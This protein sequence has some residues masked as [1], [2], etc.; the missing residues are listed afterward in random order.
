MP[1][2]DLSQLSEDWQP[3]VGPE[4]EALRDGLLRS[5]A[6]G[7]ALDSAVVEPVAIR[8]HRK[9]LICWLPETDSLAWVHLTGKAETDPRWPTTEVVSTWPYLMARLQEADRA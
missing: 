8:R 5:V 7:H 3:V 6:P 1:P 9:D 2:H 4:A